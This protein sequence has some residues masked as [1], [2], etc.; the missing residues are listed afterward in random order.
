MSA[1]AACR[2]CPQGLVLDRRHEP[3][4]SPRLP[5]MYFRHRRTHLL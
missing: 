4:S 1:G 3:R 2:T 5:A